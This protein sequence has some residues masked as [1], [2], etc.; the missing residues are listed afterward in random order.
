MEYRNAIYNGEG[1][2]NLEYNHPTQGWIPYSVCSED[3]GDKLELYQL[4]QKNGDVLAAKKPTIEQ[5]RSNA[6]VSRARFIL[7]A[8]DAGIISE[9]DA[10]QAV[11]GWPAGWDAFFDGKPARSRVAAKAEWVS[12]TTV[13]RDAPLIEE[14]RVFKDLTPEQIDQLFGIA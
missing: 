1:G 13:R 9:M 3:T 10:E 6:S 7:A 14:L 5:L 11:N 8:I 2:I 4:I 12:I